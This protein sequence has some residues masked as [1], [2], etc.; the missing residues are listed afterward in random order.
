V[1][2][3][4]KK[5]RLRAGLTQAE[6]AEKMGYERQSTAS[7]WETGDSMP[8]PRLLPEIAKLYNCTVDEL[9]ADDETKTA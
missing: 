3:R 8:N 7:M 4:I 6:L 2:D 9:L 5:Y 1:K